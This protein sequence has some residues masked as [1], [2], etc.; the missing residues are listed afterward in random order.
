[1]VYGKKRVQAKCVFEVGEEKFL[2]LLL[3]IQSEDDEIPDLSPV[4]F[5]AF[6]VVRG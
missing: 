5:R 4:L 3:V 6:R 1:M 2:V